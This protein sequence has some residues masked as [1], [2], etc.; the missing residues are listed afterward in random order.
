MSTAAIHAVT[1]RRP[2]RL[3]PLHALVAGKLVVAS[4]LFATLVVPAAGGFHGQALWLRCLVYPIG[5]LLLP[6]AWRI[7][8]PD[9]YPLAADAYLL[10]PFAFDA[11]GNSLGLYGRV[12]N[13]DNFAHLVGTFAL[14]GFAGTLLASR[15]AD[16]VVTV[17]AAAGVAA[18]FAIGIELAEWTAFTHPV[19]TGYGAY[20]DTVG[21]LAMDVVGAALGALAVWRV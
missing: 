4:L 19:A 11:A 18:T 8:G 1:A 7:R 5:L 13:F 12:D 16:R 10:A 17:L 9:S 21:D 2:R 6:V 3:E 20:R 14:A 15:S